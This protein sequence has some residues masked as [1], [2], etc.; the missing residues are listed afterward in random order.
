MIIKNKPDE[1]QNYLNDASNFHGMC[2]CVFIP[3]SENEISK[4]LRDANEKKVKVTVCGNRTGLAG[5]A[6]PQSGWLISTEKLNNVVEINKEMKYAV[7]QPA[8]ILHEFQKE[9]ESLG[10]FYP[11]DPTE[12]NCYIGGNVAANSSGAKSFKYGPTR[13]YVL[14]LKLILPNGE[15]LN[16]KRGQFIAEEFNSKIISESGYE[17]NFV[18]PDYKMPQTK[19]AA[20]YYCK[21][22][23]DLIDIF[24]GSEGTLGIITEIKLRLLDKPENILSCV[25]FFENES[26]GLNF[27]TDARNK[28]FE[29][30]KD[31]F[32]NSVNAL[33]LEFFDYYSLKF[34]IEDYPK[35]PSIANSAVWFEQEI[36]TG[37]E[38]TIL[39]GWL[40]L[41][42]LN[43]GDIESAWIAAN[44]KDRNEFKDFRHAISGKVNEYVIKHEITKTGTD[45]AVPHEQFLTFYRSAK[46]LPEKAGI[47]Y[48]VY[49]HFGDSH[50]HLNMLPKDEEELKKSK[51][52]YG[53]ICELAVNLGGTISAEHGIGKLKKE[54]LLKMYGEENILKMARLKKIFDPNYI[55]GIN[56]IFDEKYLHQI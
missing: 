49:G 13:D 41:I 51:Q 33:G 53:R 44:E 15:K 27:I 29:S 46:Y 22:G 9:V 16:I 47:D 50:I 54:Y 35:I 38:E 21:P 31:N 34:M 43:N 1:I 2:E 14:E 36:N 18:L 40:Q 8:I 4:I 12:T 10:L 20:G 23:M 48:I 56:N 45:T 30:R 28:T 25:V 19:H 24:I 52:I 32:E 6:I 37:N 5:S 3:E 42:E 26:D 7:V 17:Y 55:L 39:D 11:P